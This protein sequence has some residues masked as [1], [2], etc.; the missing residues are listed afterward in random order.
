MKIPKK[1]ASIEAKKYKKLMEQSFSG[2]KPIKHNCMKHR[3][4]I[5]MPDS[6]TKIFCSLCNKELGEFS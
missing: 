3:I 2:V 1:Y 5:D 6:Y 4:A